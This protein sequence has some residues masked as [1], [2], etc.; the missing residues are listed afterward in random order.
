MD[1]VEAMELN[2]DGLIQTH[3]VYWGWFGV[4]V[5]RRGE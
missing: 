2:E 5:M 4:G 3:C 1:F